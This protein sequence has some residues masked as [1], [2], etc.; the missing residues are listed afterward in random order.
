MVALF[1]HPLKHTHYENA[2]ISGLAV[3]GLR[4]DG[5]WVSAENY[6]PIYSAVIKIVRMLVVYQAVVEQKD[7]IQELAKSIDEDDAAE[8]ATG[9]FVIVREKMRRFMTMVVE[10]NN[11][12]P[13]D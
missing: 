9:L 5:G 11:P 6:T 2:I 10:K 13:M 7:E 3:M 1:D 12:S 8:A 4:E